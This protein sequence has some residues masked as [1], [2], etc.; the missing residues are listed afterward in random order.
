MQPSPL[1]GEGDKATL[2]TL[3]KQK[4]ADKDGG[5]GAASV[6]KAVGLNEGQPHPLGP[7][8]RNGAG[9]FLS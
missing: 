1:Q 9:P 4:A 5:D 7:A 3:G 8:L 6:A 2:R